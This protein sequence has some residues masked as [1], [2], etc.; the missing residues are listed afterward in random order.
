MSAPA[1]QLASLAATKRHACVVRDQVLDAIKS[2]GSEG[3]TGHECA[4]VLDIVKE[5]VQP[6]ISELHTDGQVRDSGQRRRNASGKKA[7]VWV[8]A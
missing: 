3:L 4:A 1:T 7:I 2:F 5:T 6:R 8:V